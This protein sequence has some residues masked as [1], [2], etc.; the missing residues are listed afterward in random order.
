MNLH[1][2][3]A[4]YISAVNPLLPVQVLVST[5]PAISP[6]GSQ[7]NTYATPG[8]LAASVGGSFTASAAGTTLTVSA[9]LTGSLWPGDALSAAGLPP[10]VS[11]VTQLSGTTG[12]IGTYQLSLDVGTLVS[13][14]LTAASTVLNV[15]S[16]SS[17]VLQVGQTML[18]IGVSPATLITSQ[19][20]GTTGGVGLY[21]LSEVQTVAPVAMATTLILNAQI[22]PMTWRDIQQ[23]EGITLQGTRWK[24][25]LYGQVDGLVRQESKGGDLIILPPPSPHA[26]TWLVVQVLE[27]WPDWVCAAITLQ[28]GS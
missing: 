8:A 20:S 4:P 5:G 9:V 22:Q 15:T 28:D 17:G 21:R 10:G 26:G 12:G 11:V 13:T 23:M 2:I 6:D 19:I 7:T 3:V 14:T 27:Q 16:V 24:I 18:G 1:G 25:Y